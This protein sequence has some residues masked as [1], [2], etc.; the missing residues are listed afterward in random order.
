MYKN[1]AFIILF[2]ILLC[3]GCEMSNLNNNTPTKLLSCDVKQLIGV[4]FDDI[5]KIYGD[6]DKS[7]YYINSKDL[8]KIN[9]DY[10]SLRDFRYHSIIRS[11]YNINKN[12]DYIILWYKNN[13]VIDAFFNEKDIINT[14]NID[15]ELKNIDIKIDYFK[16]SSY[17]KSKSTLDKYKVFIGNDIKNFNKNYNLNC[18][19]IVV[20]LLKNNK[21]FYFYNLKEDNVNKKNCLFVSTEVG[22]IT[23]IN[24]INSSKIC[25]T[26][27]NYI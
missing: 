6:A 25:E 1:I 26:I 2:S 23:H 4:T 15:N 5:E 19:Y 3:C 7:T 9:R 14:Y 8:S 11:Y 27:M 10:T 13:K 12:E 21:T 24:I 18:P 17:I 22:K 16:Y 20:N